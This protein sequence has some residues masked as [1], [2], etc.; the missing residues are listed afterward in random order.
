MDYREMTRLAGDP[1]RVRA[2]AEMIVSLEGEK[3]SDRALSFL[4][5]MRAY[6]GQ[7]PLSIRQ[8][9]ALYALRERTT[10]S[11][12]AGPYRVADL[13]QKA[14]ERRFD[15]DCQDDEQWLDQLKA[16]GASVTLSLNERRRL[17]SICRAPEIDLIPS[18][19]WI[20]LK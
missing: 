3:L 9:E 7:S 20:D 19:V 1:P 15:L 4:N 16:I 14:W 6:D 18:D 5:K 11:A 13:I 10:R 8:K 2:L 17:L 12:H